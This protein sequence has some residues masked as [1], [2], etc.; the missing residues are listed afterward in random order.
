VKKTTFSSSILRVITFSLLGALFGSLIGVGQIYAEILSNQPVNCTGNIANPG[1][2]GSTG[3]GIIYA[4]GI[5]TS[6]SSLYQIIAHARIWHNASS[7]TGQDRQEWSNSYGGST[8]TLSSTYFG[9]HG[10]TNSYFR[11]NSGCTGTTYFTSYPDNSDSCYNF[12]NSG[13]GC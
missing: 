7:I 5:S 9:D 12:W 6:S 10:V 1:T 8:A 11:A 2:T 4:T 13:N 3:S